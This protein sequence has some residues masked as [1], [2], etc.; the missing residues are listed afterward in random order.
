MHGR[1]PKVG[2]LA[3]AV[4]LLAMAA[5]AFASVRITSAAKPKGR[6]SV[7]IVRDSAGIP[8]VRARDFYRLGVGE[9]YAF[10][11]D[12]LCEL[13]NGFVTVRGER[14]KFFGPDAR[15]TV[16]TAQ[17][18]PN[19]KSDAFW[20]F[21]DKSGAIDATLKAKPPLGPRREVTQLYQGY[22]DGY[23]GYIKS[24]RLKDPRC[25][26]KPWVRK[27]TL[28]DL[29]LRGAQIAMTPTSG[30]FISG[31]FDAQPPSAGSGKR[32]KPNLQALSER[33]SPADPATGS[34]GIGLGNRGTRGKTGM[35]LANPHF[36]WRGTERFWM[37]HLTV[38]GKYDAMGGTLEGFPFVGIGFNKHM[39]WTHTVS[40]TRRFTIFQLKLA[41]GD[42]TSYLVDGQPEKMGTVTVN[43][44]T[45]S[46]TQPHTFYTTRWGP[47]VNVAQAG[48]AWTND[49]AYALA[50]STETDLGRAANQYLEM[51]QARSVRKLLAVEQKYL[52]IPTFNTVAADDRGE[53][54]YGDVGNTPNVSQAKIDACT[55]AGLPRLVFNSARIVTL[56]G[57][58]AECA[59]DTDPGTPVKGIFNGSH[60]PHLFRRDYVENSN[61]SYWLANPAS[62]LTGFSPIIGLEKTQQG[63]RT[64][65]GNEM[66]GQRFA[67]TD[68]LSKKPKFTISTLQRMWENNRSKLAELVLSDLV[69][70]CRAHPMATASN[71]QQVDLTPAC[72]ALAAYNKTGNLNARGGWLFS[73]WNRLT[74]TANFWAD[75]FD[76]N[77]PL[78]TPSKLNTGNQGAYTGLAD[79]VLE[80]QAA[81]VP[82]AAPY[83]A[84]QYTPRKGTKIPIHGCSSGCFNAI[85]ASNGLSENPTSQAPYGE[86]FTGSSL[87]M[88]TELTRK[89]PRSEGI[90]TYS[91]ATDPTSRWHANL[92]KLYSRKKWVPMRFTKRALARDKRLEVT[93]L[94]L[95]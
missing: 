68:G 80:L 63:L 48:Y 1:V 43:V 74:P 64:R 10:A 24:D 20:Q 53:A 5:P 42:P 93:L 34:N 49:T 28:R 11:E 59:W 38:P 67:A 17:S 36:P 19:V 27:I 58:R 32:T 83:G 37:T 87:V 92:T 56:D 3:I 70:G 95:R 62:P 40:T 57:S 69:A 44:D 41:P 81:G 12:N 30:Q 51:G 66:I 52:A 8:H 55:P 46:G 90:L 75:A 86:A 6:N 79:A 94:R 13:A 21:Y 15:S 39:A 22:R 88:T 73:E 18:D 85:S 35:L 77:Q 14:S 54:L 89:G 33:F 7:T 4:A 71:G 65:L 23:N 84:V 45:G 9:G 91:Q 31:I 78:T 16:F 26:G 60:M 72:D 50:N 29:Y 47:V 25:K 76:P 61:D 82:L 2:L